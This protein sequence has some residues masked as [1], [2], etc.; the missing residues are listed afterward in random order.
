M[1][2][3]S[4]S[5]GGTTGGALWETSLLIPSPSTGIEEEGVASLYGT[6]GDD[7]LAGVPSNDGT[8]GIGVQEGV[9]ASEGMAGGGVV[10]GA[11]WSSCWSHTGTLE[12]GALVPRTSS[13][14]VS[15]DRASAVAGE[16]T[17]M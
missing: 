7:D 17:G 11:S 3:F 10:G 8:A 13:M 12:S 16:S 5:S 1:L 14:E 15:A 6:A 4:R 9:S 2:E